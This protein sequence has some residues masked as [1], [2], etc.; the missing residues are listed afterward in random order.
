MSADAENESGKTKRYAQ[1]RERIV[2][3]ASVSINELGV[4]GMT[5]A[6]VGQRVDLN[7]TSITY[8]FKRKEL[9]AEAALARSI[10]LFEAAVH[11]AAREADPRARVSA[12]LRINLEEWARV[13]RREE[14]P[15]ARLSD[16]RAMTDPM[17]ARLTERWT[18]VFRALRESLFGP[19]QTADEKALRTARAAVLS[20]AIFWLPAWLNA[21]SISDFPRVHRR[22]FEIF[23]NGLA[24][25]EWRPQP[26]PISDGEAD[27][28]AEAFLR[29][30]TRLINTHGY[31]GASVE[32]IAAELDVTKGSFYHHLETKDDLVIE[33]FERSYDR[34]SRVQAAAI[35]S[36]ANACEMLAGATSSLV[37]LQF[38]GD[39]PLLRTTALQA[40]PADV[41]RHR[42]I[43]RSDRMARR[44]AGMI[45]DGVSEGSVRAV[46]PM[47][48]SQVLMASINNAYEL[49]SWA[50]RLTR[51]KAVAFYVSTLMTGL[52]ADPQI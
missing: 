6:D 9:L 48:A 13:R 8:Y 50:S 46:D 12:Y 22:L 52:F 41:R 17:R 26:S 25:N 39:F 20:E 19:A 24:L 36:G 34:V 23:E 27:G 42:V 4:K 29:A 32:R 5:F 1:T 40:L 43:E 35:A 38:F 7:T 30:A 49:R 51:E 44:F 31:R 37:D 2:E 21:Y 33:C 28:G 15:R 18:D 3:A 47:I 10:D 11:E 16:I 14:K 45:A